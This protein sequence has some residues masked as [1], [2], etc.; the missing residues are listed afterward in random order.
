MGE[1]AKAGALEVLFERSQ[2]AW[3]QLDATG[4]PVRVNAAAR[5]LLGSGPYEGLHFVDSSRGLRMAR[6]D[7]TQLRCDVERTE[8]ED[9]G[10]LVA[11]REPSARLSRAL[12]AMIS[13][14]FAEPAQQDQ[15]DA[16]AEI[17]GDALEVD[18]ALIY[19]IRFSKSEA[20]GLCEWLNPRVANLTDTKATYPLDAFRMSAALITANESWIESHTRAQHPAFVEEGSAPILHG[21]M[22][23]QSLLWF[24][25][26]FDADGFYLL[27]LNQVDHDRAWLPFEIDF[28]QIVTRVVSLAIRHRWLV[29]ACACADTAILEA[30]RLQSVRVLAGGAAHDLATLMGRLQWAVERARSVVA[31]GSAVAPSIDEIGRVTHA[32]VDLVRQMLTFARKGHHHVETIAMGELAQKALVSF[33]TLAGCKIHLFVEDSGRV[34]GDSLQ[35]RQMLL[36]LVSNAVEASS[37]DASGHASHAEI[38]IRISSRTDATTATKIAIEV[39]DL[40]HGIAPEIIDKVFEPFFSTKG[41]G[42]GLGLTAVARIAREHGGDVRV[43]SRVGAGTTMTVTLPRSDESKTRSL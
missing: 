37:R 3:I 24:P 23:I 2:E 17:T 34:E 42:R 10:Q 20:K 26:G 27:A 15:L 9:G 39:S 7:G 22:G 1:W 32:S 18:R 33:E 13:A 43:D 29:D 6:A 12:E 4:Q 30:G 8:T 31:P 19:E 11:L 5:R 16:L 36:N 41:N 21:T 28:L 14:V 35:L 38:R 40:G 25:F